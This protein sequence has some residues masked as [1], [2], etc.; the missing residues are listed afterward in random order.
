MK[1]NRSRTGPARFPDGRVGYAVGD[2]HGRADLLVRMLEKL[3]QEPAAREAGTQPVV[4]FLGD[5]VDRGPDSR[6]VIDLLLSGRPEGFEKR[7]LKGNHEAALLAFLDDPIAH[8]AW[9]GHG[10]LA[11][12]AAYDVYPLPSLGAGADQIERARDDLAQRLPPAHLRFLHE[13]ERFALLGDYLFAHAGVDPRK[14]LDEQGDSDLF[15]IR[16]RFIDDGRVLSHR[17][18]HGHTPS[19]RPYQDL[20]RIGVDTGAYFSNMLSAVRLSGEAAEF[21]SVTNGGAYA[22]F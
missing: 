7:F 6:E 3:E 19:E 21:V 4:L 14:R 9:L 5:Y 15:W 12:L 1:Q 20:R 11:T 22:G 2:V 18:V 16:R 13:L 17:I 10:G 8:K